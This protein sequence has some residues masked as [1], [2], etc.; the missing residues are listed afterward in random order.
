MTIYYKGKFIFNNYNI[1]YNIISIMLNDI[2]K[3]PTTSMQYKNKE[4][5]TYINS[6]GQAP[7]QRSTDWYK[8]R[9]VTIGGSEI[10]T[11]LE[12]NPFKSKQELIAEKIGITQGFNGNL[13]TRWGI[14]F[15]HV[16]KLWTEYIFN[17]TEE[18]REAGSIEGIIKGQRY[19][20]DGL[21]VV[22]LK[23]AD[24]TFDY[25]II[26]LEFK[27]PLGSLPN[28]KIP[29]YYLPQV[30]TGLLNIPICD[31]GIFINNCYRKCPL[32]DL[33]FTGSYDSKFHAG[34]FKKLKYGLTKHNVLACGIICFY[35][36][37]EEYDK[38]Y[39]FTGYDEYDEH[40]ENTEYSEHDENTEHGKNT[41]Y[42][43]HDENIEHD[44]PQDYFIDLDINLLFN[45]KNDPIDLGELEK[46]EFERI[47]IL[48]EEKRIHA[49][50]YPII[51]NTAEINKKEFITLHNLEKPM[52]KINCNKL[53]LEHVAKFNRFCTRNS[54]CT[55]GYL[56]WKLFRSDIISVD[57][58]EEW[59]GKIEKEVTSTLNILNTLHSHPDPKMAYYEL[60][61]EDNKFNIDE[62]E[63]CQMSSFLLK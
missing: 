53:A 60:Y 16:T 48:Y 12:L 37:T 58:D 20:P 14:L 32:E 19:S 54:Y 43:E 52:T 62:I 3:T 1:N 2:I 56:P 57:R 35:Q 11:V 45:S 25:F 44:L 51:P 31:L 63:A 23:C 22:K 8:I 55:V 17:S 33:N 5:N 36:T 61:P 15:E 24:D 4:L 6:I 26:L 49:K 30:Q 10:A 29:P 38:L 41:E 13:A 39:K 7:V 34:D 47:L 46:Y 9:K 50:F 59:L 28:G 21:T 18:I 42:S 40:G 27:S